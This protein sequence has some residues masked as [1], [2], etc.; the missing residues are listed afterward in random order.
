M[1]FLVLTALAGPPTGDGQ[2][3]KY[4]SSCELDLD[5]NGSADVVMLVETL[6]GRELL[7]LLRTEAGFHT[8]VL[9]RLP[10]SNGMHLRCSTERNLVETYPAGGDGARHETPGGYIQLVKPESASWCFY[11]SKNRFVTVVTGD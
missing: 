10:A 4:V 3:L 7:A 8:H 2:P 6:W 11:W 5:Q 1:I 9:E